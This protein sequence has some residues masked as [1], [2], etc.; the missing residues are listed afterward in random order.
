[1]PNPGT[2]RDRVAPGK[3]PVH[4]RKI[5][6]DLREPGAFQSALLRAFQL[7]P[8]YRDVFLLK[9]IQGHSLSEVAAILGINIRTAHTRLAQAHREVSLEG[10]TGAMERTR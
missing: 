4:R 8:A 9:E 1:M 2:T 7:R 6:P 5:A 10:Y 3:V